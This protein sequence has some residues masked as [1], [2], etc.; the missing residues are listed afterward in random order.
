M[1]QDKTLTR[2]V[3]GVNVKTC[4]FVTLRLGSKAPIIVDEHKKSSYG[5]NN[6]I[7]KKIKEVLAR[8]LDLNVLNSCFAVII[9]CI[10]SSF[11]DDFS[12][13]KCIQCRMIDK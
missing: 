10:C 4:K 8:T 11:N 13:T 2:K 9:I 7:N 12:V 5:R 1:F 6:G 3:I